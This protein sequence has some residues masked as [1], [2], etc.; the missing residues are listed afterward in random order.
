MHTLIHTGS[1]RF[2]TPAQAQKAAVF[3]SHIT[4]DP[5]RAYL[6]LWEIFINAIEHGNLGISYSE[7][8]EMLQSN[9]FE[10][11]ICTRL[12]A[13]EYEKRHVCVDFS[14]REDDVFFDIKDEGAGFNWHPY[15]MIDSEIL[16]QKNGRGIAVAQTMSFDEIV[17]LG[18]GNHVQCTIRCRAD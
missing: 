7:K 8:N 1:C 13:I 15:L 17:Y 5:D 12:L 11:L 3:L 4:S 16:L 18:N 9:N 6:G 14:I 2:Q 10:E